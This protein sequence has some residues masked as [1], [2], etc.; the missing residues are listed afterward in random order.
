MHEHLSKGSGDV[1][2]LHDGHVQYSNVRAMME[3]VNIYGA[4]MHAVSV[5]ILDYPPTFHR[6]FQFVLT[7]FLLSGLMSLNQVIYLRLAIYKCCGKHMIQLYE[8]GHQYSCSSHLF[9]SRSKSTF[10]SLSVS[11]FLLYVCSQ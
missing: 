10:L 1:K 5:S 7:F 2:S 3:A 9:D 11:L 8:L 4:E 6:H